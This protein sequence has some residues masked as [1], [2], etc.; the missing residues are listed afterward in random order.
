MIIGMH[1]ELSGSKV[2]LIFFQKPKRGLLRNREHA[3]GTCGQRFIHPRVKRRKG[4][5]TGK[6]HS[7]DDIW[8]GL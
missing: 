6:L 2:R 4:N 3:G 1:M 7:E 5:E 8:R